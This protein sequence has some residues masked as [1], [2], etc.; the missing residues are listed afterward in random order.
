MIRKARLQLRIGVGLDR[1]RRKY[2]E[3]ERKAEY[4][5][6]SKGLEYK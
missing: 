3:N 6:M 1:K 5:C 4:D 2:Q